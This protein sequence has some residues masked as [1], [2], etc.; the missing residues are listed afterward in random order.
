M[1]EFQQE[2]ID[3]DWD[4]ALNIEAKSFETGYLEAQK[5]LQFEDQRER[6]K[7]SGYSNGYSI[8]FEVGFV[9]ESCGLYVK[10]SELN[11]PD[12]IVSKCHQIREKCLAISDKVIIS[13]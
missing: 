8:G 7:L 1:T 11:N 13:K 9:E 4:A 2:S 5:E 12:R 6:G 10:D 3:S